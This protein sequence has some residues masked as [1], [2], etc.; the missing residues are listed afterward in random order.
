MP[1]FT[2][3][4]GAKVGGNKNDTPTCCCEFDTSDPG[5]PSV[6]FPKT[7][8]IAT[9]KWWF[10]YYF[11]FQKGYFREYVSSREVLCWCLKC[12]AEGLQR[13]P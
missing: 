11:P 2:R 9:E 13:L 10:G 6:S 7:N 8:I 12:A 4:V 1:T 3:G 5:V